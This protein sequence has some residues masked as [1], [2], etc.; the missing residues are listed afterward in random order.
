MTSLD[1]HCFFGRGGCTQGQKNPKDG[2]N[3]FFKKQH[4]KLGLII[5][6]MSSAWKINTREM[7]E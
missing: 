2:R 7:E 6:G 4:V 3:A 1:A 5:G